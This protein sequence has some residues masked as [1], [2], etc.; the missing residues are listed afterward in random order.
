MSAVRPPLVA[1]VA[2][3]LLGG[4]WLLRGLGVAIDVPV[5]PLLLLG[6]GAVV[7]AAGLR[8][9]PA[10]PGAGAGMTAGD[11]AMHVAGA[12]PGRAAAPP[13]DGSAQAAGATAVAAPPERLALPTDGAERAR[14]I[15]EHGAGSV[16]LH[17]GASSGLLLEGGFDGGVRPEVRRVDGVL[18]VR[19]RGFADVSGWLARGRALTWDIS[20]ADDVPLAIELST[21][22]SR[23]RADL[24]G[25]R[26]ERLDVRTGASDVEVVLPKASCALSV[27]AGAADVRVRVPEGLA[28]G[29]RNRTA[30]AGFTVDEL[31]FLRTATGYATPDYDAAVERAEI[32]LEGGVA[33][34]SVR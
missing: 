14:I 27:S 3:V 34:F 23:V 20:L 28:A 11:P 8:E 4:L 19:L 2:L 15:V 29:I 24:T 7:L 22:A 26:T 10:A 30:V 31:R 9:R 25:T 1:G 13:A 21:G 18:E 32:D 16:R 17:G 12:G 5:G 33:S 6:V